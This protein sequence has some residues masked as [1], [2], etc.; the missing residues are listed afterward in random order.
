MHKVVA[1]GWIQTC[2]AHRGF[3]VAIRVRKRPCSPRTTASVFHVELFI[4]AIVLDEHTPSQDTFQTEGADVQPPTIPAWNQTQA[5]ETLGVTGEP[6]TATDGN[7][8]GYARE[9][10]IAVSPLA[11]LPHKTRFHELAHCALGHT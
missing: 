8:Q 3:P 5:L 7:C 10:T 1:S 6:L 9:R 11:E 2:S 4:E